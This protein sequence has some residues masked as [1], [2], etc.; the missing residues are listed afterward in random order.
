MTVSIDMRSFVGI[1]YI[2]GGRDPRPVE[3]GGDGGVDC[4]GLLRLSLRSLGVEIPAVQPAVA[5]SMRERFRQ[6]DR[7]EAI[8]LGDVAVIETPDG[9]LHVAMAIDQ[10]KFLHATRGAASVIDAVSMWR[11]SIRCW[12]RPLHLVEAGR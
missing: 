8:E 3:H 1:P 2:D 12:L 7:S 10:F 5:A 6:L 11:A 9:G 4:W